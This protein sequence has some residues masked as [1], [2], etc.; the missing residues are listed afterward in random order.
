RIAAPPRSAPAQSRREKPMLGHPA[1]ETAHRG[2]RTT[3]RS[4]GRLHPRRRPPPRWSA[5]RP[6]PEPTGSPTPGSPDPRPPKTPSPERQ[7]E[8]KSPSPARNITKDGGTKHR[9][10]LHRDCQRAQRLTDP[11]PTTAKSDTGRQTTTANPTP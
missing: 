11:G 4:L 9:H 5:P 2:R 8:K 6:A 7:Q 3:P 1:L 10:R